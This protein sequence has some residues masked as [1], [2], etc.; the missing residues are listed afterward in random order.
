MNK[1]LL[2]QIINTLE[3]IEVK[4]KDNLSKLLGCISALEQLAQEEDNGRQ[5]DK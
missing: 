5:D 2:S 1:T 4:G 3:T